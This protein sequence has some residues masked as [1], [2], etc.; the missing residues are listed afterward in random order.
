MLFFRVFI[1]ASNDLNVNILHAIPRQHCDS[2]VVSEQ[3]KYEDHKSL[4]HLRHIMED[5]KYNA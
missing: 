3:A 5:I 1:S 4:I 2:S